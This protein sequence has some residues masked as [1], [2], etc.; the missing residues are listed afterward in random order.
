MLEWQQNPA[1][2]A[3]LQKTWTDDFEV[4]FSLGSKMYM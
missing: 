4:L 3:L 2:T 1:D